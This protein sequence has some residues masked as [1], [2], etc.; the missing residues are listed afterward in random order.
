[1]LP[2]PPPLVVVTVMVAVSVPVAGKA[3]LMM[4]VG[5]KLTGLP[6]TTLTVTLAAASAR[7]QHWAKSNAAS[8]IVTSARFA[9]I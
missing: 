6:L 4:S 7:S 3:A 1:M 8:A 5:A 9:D 2:P